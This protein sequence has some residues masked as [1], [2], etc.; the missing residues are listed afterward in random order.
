MQ[1]R[2]A[3]RN[4]PQTLNE[5]YGRIL[6][7]I[8]RQHE[9]YAIR[10][11]QLLIYSKRRLALQEV[12]DAIVVNADERPHFDVS[13][14]MPNPREIINSCSSLVSIVGGKLSE[15]NLDESSWGLGYQ[16]GLESKLGE[17]PE[18]ESELEDMKLIE[19]KILPKARSKKKRKGKKGKKGSKI[20]GESKAQGYHSYKEKHREEKK[21]EWE[22]LQL[23][24]FSVR[25]YLVSGALEGSFKTE[26]QEIYARKTITRVCLAYMTNLEEEVKMNYLNNWTDSYRS[27]RENVQQSIKR[28]FPFAGYSA[29]YWMDHANHPL[30]LDDMGSQIRNFI[31]R[32]SEVYRL[33]LEISEPLTIFEDWLMEDPQPRLSR[34]LSYLILAEADAVVEFILSY[35]ADATEMPD[36]RENLGEGLI[37]ASRNGNL[38]LVQKLLV[39]GADVNYYGEGWEIPSPL[40]AACYLG[41]D[42]V[43]QVLLDYGAFTNTPSRAFPSALDAVECCQSWSVNHLHDDD[44]HKRSKIRQMLHKVR[45]DCAME[46]EEINSALIRASR[47]MHKERIHELLEAGADINARDEEY[48][49]ALINAVNDCHVNIVQFLLNAGA[50]VN[51]EGGPAG[52]A[53]VAASACNYACFQEK[54]I[55]EAKNAHLEI[56]QILLDAGANINA[57]VGNLGP[58]LVA[59]SAQGNWRTAELLLRFG[60]EVDAQG[61]LGTALIA[62]LVNGHR[63]TA[64]TLLHAGAN[65]YAGGAGYS[66]A[67]SAAR[68]KEHIMLVKWLKKHILKLKKRKLQ[69]PASGANE[70]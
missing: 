26:L 27:L 56:I 39:Y 54:F 29:G 17:I 48:C 52:S 51:A 22:L 21:R 36:W 65:V 18:S 10:I 38:P 42:P 8:P 37:A 58:A 57:K 47:W 46:P 69:L 4:L 5:T 13:W 33:S 70:T 1:L 28:D 20:K 25:E 62:A 6:A 9:I 60:A 34:S 67:I 45:T 59:A 2:K 44:A 50:D 61:E 31:F 23:A 55:D 15:M 53:L 19:S 14:R 40:L 12:V 49:T 41:H 16:L 63:E 3:I 64:R 30:V 66:D 35:A 43:V 68:N 32:Q 11:L 24:H 7:N